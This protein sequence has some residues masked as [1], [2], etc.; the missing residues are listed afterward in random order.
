MKR[1]LIL[2]VCLLL[3]G[4]AVPA[5]IPASSEP[6]G[7]SPRSTGT[8]P[9]PS[10]TAPAQTQPSAPAETAAVPSPAQAVLEGM[11]TEEK[12]WQLFILTPEQ[13]TG[14]GPVTRAGERTAEALQQRPVGGLIYFSQNLIDGEQIRSLL[15]GAQAASR[16]PLFLCVDEEGGSVSR[17]GGKPGTGVPE[18]P[19][20]G[21]TKDAS[22]AYMIGANLGAAL[23]ELGFNV[24]F[25][26]VADVNSNPDNP[27]IGSRA[28]SSEAK[29]AAS[30]VSSCV[31]GFL[32]SGLLCALKH[33]PGHGDTGADSHYGAAVLEKDRA[34]LEECELL[35]F[36]AGCDAGAP[37]V[38]VG[39]ISVPMVTGDNLPA[40]LSPQIVKDLLRGELDFDGLIV[41]DSMQMGAITNRYSAGE[42]AVAAITAGVDIILMPEDADAAFR[43]IQDALESGA[44]TQERIDESVLRILEYKLSLGG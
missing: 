33:F 8:A 29:L 19:P 17:L 3:T 41:T 10:E 40:S 28:F 14:V 2:L 5:G 12:L 34:A 37:L 11:S 30:L 39:H 22:E 9:S 4:C 18:L 24:D 32:D 25:A 31:R 15:S 6:A 7:T 36:R 1:L 26:P 20:M 23:T 43:G 42:A 21:N 44:L 16:L 35:P 13:L 38:M 27:V